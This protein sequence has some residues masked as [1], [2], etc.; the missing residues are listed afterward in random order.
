MTNSAAIYL[1]LSYFIL[2]Y[3]IYLFILFYFSLFYLPTPLCFIAY[4]FTLFACSAISLPTI[5]FIYIF[6]FYSIFYHRL[7]SCTKF[8]CYYFFIGYLHITLSITSANFYRLLQ[9]PL[10]LPPSPPSPRYKPHVTQIHKHSFYS[11]CMAGWWVYATHI[12]STLLSN[13]PSQYNSFLI[14][15]LVFADC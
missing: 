5:L 13:G 3:F 6:I 15:I 2:V 11:T 12:Y 14:C 8:L 9:P 10:L 1:I 7:Y 4:Y